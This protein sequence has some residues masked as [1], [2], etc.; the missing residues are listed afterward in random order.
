MFLVLVAAASN[1][2]HQASA[3]LAVLTSQPCGPLL[4]AQDC[5]HLEHEK[6]ATTVIITTDTSVNDDEGT[7][8]I[9]LK[10]AEG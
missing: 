7:V 6:N 1:M 9:V 2:A 5:L 10:K 3:M 4:V 8:Q